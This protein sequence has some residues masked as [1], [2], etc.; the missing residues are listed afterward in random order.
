MANTSI[1]ESENEIDDSNPIADL[2][3]ENNDKQ[4]G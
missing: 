3:T 4:E 1:D 2:E